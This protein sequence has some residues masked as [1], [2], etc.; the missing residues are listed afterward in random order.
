M[1]SSKILANVFISCL[2]VRPRG[3]GFFSAASSF[4]DRVRFPGRG[5][6]ILAQR[7]L[8]VILLQV[9]SITPDTNVIK[10]WCWYPGRVRGG[11]G[12]RGGAK[13]TDVN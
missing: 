9:F 3:L 10:G 4:R 12:G 2:I 1:C 7:D 13:S 5:R 11:G 8:H 6:P